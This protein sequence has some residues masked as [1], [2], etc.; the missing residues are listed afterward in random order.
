MEFAMLSQLFYTAS[1][2]SKP[3][4]ESKSNVTYSQLL[5]NDHIIFNHYIISPMTM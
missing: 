4:G 3:S 1:V 5:T 2:H